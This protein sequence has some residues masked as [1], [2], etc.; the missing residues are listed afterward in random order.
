MQLNFRQAVQRLSQLNHGTTP[1]S[2]ANDSSTPRR[3]ANSKRMVPDMGLACKRVAHIHRMGGVVG[4]ALGGLDDGAAAN[5]QESR[6]AE[7]T[8]DNDDAR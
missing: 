2:A 4:S 7:R 1:D 8:G 5:E 3:D 6:S